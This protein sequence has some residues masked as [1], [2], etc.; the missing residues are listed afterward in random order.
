M[1]YRVTA[2]FK[3]PDDRKYL[4]E[5]ETE[6]EADTSGDAYTEGLTLFR[7]HCDEAGLDHELFEVHVGTP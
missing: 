6:I 4:P 3:N 2:E 1:K 5:W 7:A